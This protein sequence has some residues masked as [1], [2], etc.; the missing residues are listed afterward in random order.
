MAALDSPPFFTASGRAVAPVAKACRFAS[1]GR[2]HACDVAIRR[3]PSFLVTAWI[4]VGVVVAAIYD[5]FD[6]VDTAGG[7]ASAV[8]AALLWPLLL[9][10]FD[11][12]ISR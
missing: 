3:R 2:G 8:V 4:V 11:V 1:S 9:F 12:R 5:Y 7:V 10:G 6:R